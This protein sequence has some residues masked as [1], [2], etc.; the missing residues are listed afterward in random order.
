MEKNI[1]IDAETFD[2]DFWTNNKVK[3]IKIL[4]KGRKIQDIRT[5][6]LLVQLSYATTHDIVTQLE[7]GGYILREDRELRLVENWEEKF[8]KGVCIASGDR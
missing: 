1:S 6:S 4:S 7:R 5:L 8:R 3:V 2:F